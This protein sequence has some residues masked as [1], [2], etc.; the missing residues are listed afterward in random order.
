MDIRQIHA[1][2]RFDP[3]LAQASQQEAPPAA[4]PS[5]ADYLRQAMDQVVRDQEVAR[6]MA[7][8][9]AAGNVRDLA[10]VMVASERAALS[11]GL[12]VQ[13]RNKVLEA[14]QEIMRMPL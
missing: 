13:V 12:V 7:V 4:G 5:F 11:L 14:Y 9:L 10:E 6:D 1:L 3:P 8:Q 2:L